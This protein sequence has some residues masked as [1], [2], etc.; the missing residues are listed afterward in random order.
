M[1]QK[2]TLNEVYTQI[3]LYSCDFSCAPYQ[4]CHFSKLFHR[5]TK[6][7]SEKQYDHLCIFVFFFSYSV[8]KL[9]SATVNQLFSRTDSKF[10]R[11]KYKALG[12]NIWSRISWE[13]VFSLFIRVDC[14]IIPIRRSQA[15]YFVFER[16]NYVCSLK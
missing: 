14:I 2:K 10:K 13:L 12:S 9:S 15:F 5:L 3:S 8:D 6:T 4:A 16:K 11:K 7:L 1:Y